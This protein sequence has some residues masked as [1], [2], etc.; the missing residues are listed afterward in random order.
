M[1]VAA[2]LQTDA[3]AVIP[4]FF[5]GERLLNICTGDYPGQC[6]MYVAGV[7]DG[8]FLAESNNEERSICGGRL[9]NRDAAALVT[10]Y[11]KD[12]PGMLEK[13]AAVA[14]KAALESELPCTKEGTP[15]VQKAD[16]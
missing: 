10:S 5:T 2:S 1:L 16:T 13:A 12:N 3:P 8:F 7:L 9:T 11:L 15:E 14:V 4:A 6:W